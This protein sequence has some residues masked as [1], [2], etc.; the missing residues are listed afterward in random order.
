MCVQNILDFIRKLYDISS[1]ET[2]GLHTSYIGEAEK[3][4]VLQCLDHGWVAT[5][6]PETEELEVRLAALTG[7]PE[8][9]ATNSGTAALHLALLGAGVEE[10]D[11]VL[12]QALSFVATGNAIAYIKAKALFIDVDEDTLSM[13]P[14]ALERWLEEC[15]EIRAMGA[16]HKATGRRIAACLPM[17]T[18]GIIGRIEEISEICE[19]WNIPLVEDAAEALGSFRNSKHAGTTGIA[20]I[21]SFN[22]N[23]IL[24]AGG[25]GAILLKDRSLAERLRHLSTQAKVPHPWEYYHNFIGYNYRMPA[26]NAALLLGQL[27][28]LDE[29]LKNKIETHQEYR[30]F[31][32]NSIF[33]I[34]NFPEG[35]NHWLNA[36]RIKD[37][38]IR[39]HLLEQSHISGLMMRPL[40]GLMSDFPMFCSKYHDSLNISQMLVKEI[41]NLPSGYRGANVAKGMIISSNDIPPC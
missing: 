14:S 15:A 38:N 29:I 27:D 18:F 23:K 12:T 13:S 9:V 17:H 35:S 26:L 6:G 39:T 32:R 11:I 34:V 28:N 2:L 3:T 19:K 1:G 37:E 30:K 40:W 16:Y 7:S 25:G 22:G 21:L 41:V 36:V 20:G 31:F 24:T 5:N 10:E 8:A 33:E 4:R